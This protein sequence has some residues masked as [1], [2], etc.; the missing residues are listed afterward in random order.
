MKTFRSLGPFATGLL[1]GLL[2]L[3]V[4]EPVD[5]YEYERCRGSNETWNG[6]T[7]TFRATPISFPSGSTFRTAL[8]SASN[9][10]NQD[11][12]GSR[13]RFAIVYQDSS[14]YSLGDGNNSILFTSD[15]DWGPGTQAVARSRRSAC[16]WPFWRSR[17]TEA[18][19]LFNPARTWNTATQP[20]VPLST[21]SE[22]FTIVAL[23]ELGHTFG[24]NHENDVM[25]TMD[26]FYPDSGPIGNSNDVHPHADDSLGNRVGYGTAATERDF[27]A[28]AF[29]RTGGGSSREITTRGTT[30]RGIPQAFQ[31]TISNRGTVNQSGLRVQFYLSTDRNITTGD[32]LLGSATFGLNAGITSTPTANVTV[33]TTVPAGNYFFGYIVDPTRQITETDEGNNA[34]AHARRTFVTAATPPNQAPRA[35]FSLTPEFGSAPLTVTA[36]ASCSSDVDGTIVSYTWDWGDGGISSGQSRSHTFFEGGDYQVRLTVRDDDGASASTTRF[37][38]VACGVGPFCEELN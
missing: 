4:P 30:F 27:A 36:N 26:E 25:G 3:A 9:G 32:R 16:A 7:Q 15:W 2:F 19:I 34:V 13:F 5:A 14:S 22:N 11:T 20:G 18:D 21:T 10:W 33:P 24:L 23:H 12:P 28:S 35:C 38:F 29:R 8:N 17:I 6:T 37:L 1:A 31:F